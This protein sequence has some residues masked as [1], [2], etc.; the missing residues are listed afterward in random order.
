MPRNA[1]RSSTAIVRSQSRRFHFLDRPDRA[2]DARVVEHDI[3]PP[4]FLDRARD[5]GLDIRLAGHV[6][7]LKHRAPAGRRAFCDGGL[8]SLR[9]KSVSTTLAPSFANRSAVARPIPLAAPVITATFPWILPIAFLLRAIRSRGIL[10]R[11]QILN[12]ND[13]AESGS[14]RADAKCLSAVVYRAGRAVAEFSCRRDDVGR[15]LEFH[16]DFVAL[17]KTFAVAFAVGLDVLAIS[18]GVGVARLTFNASLRLGLAFAGSEIAMQMIGYA[19]G[20]GA[21]RVLG[22][23]AA[24]IGFALLAFIGVVMI[25]NSFRHSIRGEIR[26]D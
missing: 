14:A 11:S 5:R 8:A 23:V 7:A 18:V 24:Y 1:A 26:C 16:N 20:V 17:G 12:S 13:S 10:M 25:R 21:G 4:V 22:D 2:R 9:F 15:H 6:G 19:L 3:E